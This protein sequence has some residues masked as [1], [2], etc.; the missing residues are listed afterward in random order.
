MTSAGIGL[1]RQ[2]IGAAWFATVL[3]VLPAVGAPLTAKVVD[4]SGQPVV[5]AVVYA[6]ASTGTRPPARGAE[7]VVIEQRDREFV[8]FVTPIQVGTTVHFPNRDPLLHHVYSFSPAKTFEIKLY[9]GEAPRGFLFDKPG[10]V[11]LGCNIHDWMIGYIYVLETPYFAKTGADGHARIG[12]IAA[13]EFEIHVWHPLQR[14]AAS[15]QSIKVDARTGPELNFVLNV[16]PR[17][18]KFKPPLDAVRYK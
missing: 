10:T 5:D 18:K 6:M 1:N 14:N 7:T 17:K 2:W 13:G 11:I 12:N 3:A 9:A 16:A 8:P 4:A 15:P